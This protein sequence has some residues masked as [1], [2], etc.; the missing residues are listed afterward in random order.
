MSADRGWS[1]ICVPICRHLRSISSAPPAESFPERSS[2]WA[3]GGSGTQSKNPPRWRCTGTS[4]GAG[5]WAEA[6]DLRSEPSLVVRTGF[7]DSRVVPHLSA[8]DDHFRSE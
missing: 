8:H 3:A 7:F 1:E 6:V 2:E 5:E 4:G